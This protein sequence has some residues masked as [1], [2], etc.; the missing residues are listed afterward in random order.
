MNVLLTRMLQAVHHLVVS[1]V[2]VGSPDCSAA[3]HFPP[4]LL[5]PPAVQ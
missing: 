4:R 5:R 3:V 1:I 2:A